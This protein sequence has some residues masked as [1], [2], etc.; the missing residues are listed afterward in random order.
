M[1]YLILTRFYPIGPA[2]STGPDREN[3]IDFIP[4]H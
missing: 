1:N 3:I 4:L 2:F